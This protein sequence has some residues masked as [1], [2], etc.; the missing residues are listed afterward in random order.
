MVRWTDSDGGDAELR[1]RG[2]L[3]SDAQSWFRMMEESDTSPN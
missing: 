3:V 2:D 1:R